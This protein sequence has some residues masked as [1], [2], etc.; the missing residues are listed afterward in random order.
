MYTYIYMCIYI[1]H[2]YIKLYIQPY[3]DP[4]V[5]F[6]SSLDYLQYLIQYKYYVN[7]R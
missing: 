6:K 2:I 1:T 4:P 5:Y 7:S 3:T